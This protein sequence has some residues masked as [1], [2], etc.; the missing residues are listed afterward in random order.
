MSTPSSNAESEF[1]QLLQIINVSTRT[2]SGAYNDT[3][4]PEPSVNDRLPVQVDQQPG[5]K[6]ATTTLVA[7]CRQLIAS[8]TEP[9]VY[10]IE[11]CMGVSDIL[12]FRS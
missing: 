5:T 11:S 9:A 2:I 7:A 1:S 6:Q 3:G 4:L 12:S 10:A 8:V